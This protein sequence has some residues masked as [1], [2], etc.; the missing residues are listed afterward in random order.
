MPLRMKSKRS[1]PRKQSVPRNL[2]RVSVPMKV[3]CTDML[4]SGVFAI[5]PTSA[6]QLNAT[7]VW[8]AR[9]SNI[10]NFALLTG[11]YDQYKIHSVELQIMPPTRDMS[12]LYPALHANVV[13][14][15]G[16][17]HTVVDYDDVV[18]PAN[19]DVIINRCNSS[20]HELNCD[21]RISFAPRPTF[22][23][24]DAGALTFQQ[25]PRETWVDCAQA[26]VEHLGLK[27]AYTFPASS[28]APAV[29]NFPWQLPMIV[30]YN[31]EFKYPR[32]G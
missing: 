17:L 15:T 31:L 19:A 28:M 16:H 21:R 7:G 3:R 23:A 26:G 29:T 30:T 25:I 14:G 8:I 10:P 18:P 24:E 22:S 20:T 1:K 5:A 9:L 4:A 32:L 27:F 6:S 12:F 11:V 13:I 2:A